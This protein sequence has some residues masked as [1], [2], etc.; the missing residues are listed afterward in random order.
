MGAVT[1]RRDQPPDR[2][3]WPSVPDGE[4][5]CF[6]EG[7][8]SAFAMPLRALTIGITDVPCLLGCDVINADTATVSVPHLPRIAELVPDGKRSKIRFVSAVFQP[9]QSC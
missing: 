5:A 2:L 1:R 6:A 9:R 4:Y 8:M 3:D 7:P